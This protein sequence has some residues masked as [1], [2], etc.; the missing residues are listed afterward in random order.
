MLV[1][2][3]SNSSVPTKLQMLVERCCSSIP[4]IPARSVVAVVKFARKHSVN[5]GIVASVVQNWTETTTP[6][7]TSF[8]SDGAFRR[9]APEKP[10]CFSPDSYPHVT[11]GDEKQSERL[12]G[13]FAKRT[14]LSKW[15]AIQEDHHGNEPDS[16][17]VVRLP[18]RRS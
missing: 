9:R 11:N 16:H 13:T 8:G 1:G 5:A 10:R 2:A 14:S 6:P 15:F 17:P 7:L 3:C 4:T 18:S 12:Q